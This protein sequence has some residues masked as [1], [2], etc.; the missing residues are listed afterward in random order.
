[1]N[2]SNKPLPLVIGTIWYDDK[3]PNKKVK[4]GFYISWDWLSEHI[5]DKDSQLYKY[6]ETEVKNKKEQLDKKHGGVE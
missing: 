6:L 2:N 1:M 5:E 4:E 3:T